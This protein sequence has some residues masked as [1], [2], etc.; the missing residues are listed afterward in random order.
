MAESLRD[1]ENRGTAAVSVSERRTHVKT[2][3]SARVANHAGGVS[4][5]TLRPSR[6][7]G[8][9]SPCGARPVFTHPARYA[10]VKKHLADG[11]FS[12]NN[13]TSVGSIA[14]AQRTS[15][16]AI[17]RELDRSG[18]LAGLRE[19]MRREKALKHL[20][21]EQPVESDEETDSA[22]EGE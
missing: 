1:P 4:C 7:A 10:P 9:P 20:L 22:S 5:H 16:T 19:Q 21:G 17:R 12:P 8:T 13:L 2:S 6:C 3:G 11:Y 18:R 14:R 15:T